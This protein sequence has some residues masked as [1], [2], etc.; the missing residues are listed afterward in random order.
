M[1]ILFVL[2]SAAT[3]SI[4][5]ALRDQIP[6]AGVVVARTTQGAADECHAAKA[7]CVIVTADVSL[8]DAAE[9][10]SDLRLQPTRIAAVPV[11]LLSG[12]DDE[13]GRLAAFEAGAD[14]VLPWPI[15]MRVLAAHLDAL[16]GFARRMRELQPVSSAH[17]LPTPRT[18]VTID[19][20]SPSSGVINVTTIASLLAMID[21][22]ELSGELSVGRTQ[23]ARVRLVL[24]I[25]GGK[26]KGGRLPG[27][28]LS[29]RD[30]LD[31]VLQ[32]S[33]GHYTFVPKTDLQMDSLEPPTPLVPQTE[34]EKRRSPAGS[35]S[36][37]APPATRGF[38]GKT[39]QFPIR[40][41]TLQS[42]PA[43]TGTGG[44]APRRI[45]S[46]VIEAA[47]RRSVAGMPQI[48]P[49]TVVNAPRES[50]TATTEKRGDDGAGE[51]D[52]KS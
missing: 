51:K 37:P 23:T 40:R 4:S 42:Q 30:A 16:L 49:P 9:L 12:A 33:S 15:S 50:D 7:H 24:D 38:G 44:N 11:V 52:R 5:G 43:I 46:I 20:S 18:E 36:A 35:S 3:N 41:A 39:P 14:L 29:G 19:A 13:A 45:P 17:S 27:E 31:A 28:T 47:K 6:A 2:E 25:A 21:A 10:I 8:D 22:K 1:A 32:W 34:V 48:Q 26:I